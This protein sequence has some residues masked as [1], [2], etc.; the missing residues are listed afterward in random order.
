MQEHPQ[1]CRQSSAV[2]CGRQLCAQALKQP[3][4]QVDGGVFQKSTTT[5]VATRIR[6]PSTMPLGQIIAVIAKSMSV[7][8]FAP[9]LQQA[10]YKERLPSFHRPLFTKLQLHLCLVLSDNPRSSAPG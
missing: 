9:I 7:L 5:D 1:H 6:F 4:H 3:G 8:G 2:G 10:T